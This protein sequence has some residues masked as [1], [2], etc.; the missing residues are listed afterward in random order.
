MKHNLE[1]RVLAGIHAGA[2]ARL[3]GGR[4]IIGSAED[5]DVILALDD[6]AE[7][8]AM[9][10]IDGEGVAIEP[11]DGE[12]NHPDGT[13][14][15]RREPLAPF[16]PI[17]LGATVIAVAAADAAWPRIDVAA[18]QRRSAV[19]DAGTADGWPAPV[20]ASSDAGHPSPQG[21]RAVAARPF[22]RWRRLQFDRFTLYPLSVLLVVGIG[23]IGSTWL[24]RG[25]AAAVGLP[26][27]AP[28]AAPSPLHQASAVLS[29]LGMGDGLEVRAL[30]DRTLL[31]TGYVEL[32]AQKATLKE[33]MNVEG[34]EVVHRVWAQEDMLRQARNRVAQ[35]APGLEVEIVG[36]GVVRLRGYL[37]D[38]D[39]R[40]RVVMA[41][42]EDVPGIRSVVDEIVSRADAERFLGEAL[43]NSPLAGR[44]SL[45]PTESGI[46][47]EG[48]LSE[49]ELGIWSEVLA[50]FRARYGAEVPV[51]AAFVPR[52]QDLPFTLQAVVAGPPGFVVTQGGRRVMKGGDLGEGFML[53]AIGKD[54]LTIRRGAQTFVQR[55]RE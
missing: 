25:D 12:V 46:T 37:A 20:A 44:V 9:L 17:C 45:K 33:R 1:L 54:E 38:A 15:I 6:I 26:P 41:M 50:V 27:H 29:A 2:K 40:N 51:T 55:F 10:L 49:D 34:V 22:A 48:V 18:I 3:W 11:V 52:P 43:A 31:L 42:R 5:C 21:S 30:G 24:T 35:L 36:P 16:T 13:P 8:H 28:T 47:A 32:S 23:F 14:V 19:A 53:E 4:V 7:H 39:R